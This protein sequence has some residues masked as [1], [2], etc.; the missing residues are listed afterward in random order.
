MNIEPYLKQHCIR[1]VKELSALME[2][3]YSEDV[4][5]LQAMLFREAMPGIPFQI[6]FLSRFQGAVN[7]YPPIELL[8]VLEALVDSEDYV[9]REDAIHDCFDL[10]DEQDQ[11]SCMMDV[12]AKYNDENLKV[13]KWFSQC[14]IDAGGSSF[15]VAA[16]LVEE[17]F[18]FHPIDLK[19]GKLVRYIPP[20]LGI[21]MSFQF[22]YI[23]MRRDAFLSLLGQ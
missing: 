12:C 3:E 22:R 4:R 1:L 6:N 21:K 20:Y 8:S 18:Q 10:G 2:R 15:G 13:A 5:C 14:W 19:T 9:S 7:G 16:Y 23:K 17:D 11:E